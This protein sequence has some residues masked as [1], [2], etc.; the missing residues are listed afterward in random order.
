LGN[1]LWKEVSDIFDSYRTTSQIKEKQFVENVMMAV[2]KS[3][4]NLGIAREAH[5]SYLGYK[6]REYG[7]EEYYLN[8]VS[9]FSSFSKEGLVPK[10]IEFLGGGSTITVAGLAATRRELETVEFLNLPQ[11]VIIMF[12]AGG[13]AILAAATVISKVWKNYH[14]NNKR[15]S[16]ENEYKRDWKQKIRPS[17]ADCLFDLY[18]DLRFIMNK[19]YPNYSETGFITIDADTSSADDN[20]ARTII[21][22]EIIQP[23]SVE[24][25]FY[26]PITP[27]ATQEEKEKAKTTQEEKEKAKTT[28][29]EKEKAKTTQEEKQKKKEKEKA[30]DEAAAKEDP[31]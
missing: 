17:M 26:I 12:I 3:L 4:R 20:R 15:E 2:G 8:E 7:E 5:V 28:Q 25:L 13:V 1:E 27:R 23:A 29:E 6:A 22:E 16:M 18:K 30:Q 21:E 10:I 31:E 14:L 19:F 11:D 24:R 9:S